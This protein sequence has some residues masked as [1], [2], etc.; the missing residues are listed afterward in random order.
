MDGVRV[1]VCARVRVCV[2]LHIFAYMSCRKFK[3]S[4]QDVIL[5]RRAI[6]NLNNV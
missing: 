5:S 6:Y 3:K 2:L 4:I 1:C